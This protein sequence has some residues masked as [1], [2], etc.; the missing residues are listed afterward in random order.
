MRL[1]LTRYLR[2]PVPESAGTTA[3]STAGATTGGVGVGVTGVCVEP[4][5]TTPGP[6]RS[7]RSAGVRTGGGSPGQALA[8]AVLEV[9]L[10]A[11]A[12]RVAFVAFLALGRWE[13]VTRLAAT[14]R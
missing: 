10:L 1:P 4:L 6:A 5:S 11:G 2:R 3:G 7:G 8:R 14:S 13:R 9:V 12:F